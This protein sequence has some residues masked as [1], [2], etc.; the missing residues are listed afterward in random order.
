MRPIKWKSIGGQSEQGR[1]IR[2]RQETSNSIEEYQRAPNRTR[3]H[4]RAP[5]SIKENQ[6]TLKDMNIDEYHW[7]LE[8]HSMNFTVVNSDNR[9]LLLTTRCNHTVSVETLN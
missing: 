4:Q 1:A 9:R 8:V 7:N 2:E 6:G 3:E 5:G